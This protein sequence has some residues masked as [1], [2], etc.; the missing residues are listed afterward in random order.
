MSSQRRMHLIWVFKSEEEEAFSMP[1]E[2]EGEE[3]HL[4]RY[5]AGSGRQGSGRWR[6]RREFGDIGGK[7]IR[8]AKAHRSIV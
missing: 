6:W 3:E 1:R 4:Q 2:W 5:K 8:L 7:L